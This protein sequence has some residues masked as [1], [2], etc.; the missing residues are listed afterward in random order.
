MEPLSKEELAQFA[1]DKRRRKEQARE[2]RR[3][4]IRHALSQLL[5]RIT[6]S[7]SAIAVTGMPLGWIALYA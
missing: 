2:I 4:K 5:G 7:R 1:Y 6:K 3:F